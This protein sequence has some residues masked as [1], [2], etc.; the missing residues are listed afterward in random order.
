MPI[1]KSAI[2][3]MRQTKVRAKRRLP[4]KS[5]MKTMVQKV[6][7]LA[8]EGKKEEAVKTLPLAMK[9]VDM[10]VKRNIIHWKTGARRKSLMCRAVK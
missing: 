9:S 3:R 7:L 4:Y 2:K 10:A 8:K 1:I 5:R 6:L